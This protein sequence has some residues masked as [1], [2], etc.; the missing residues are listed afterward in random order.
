MIKVSLIKV[1]VEREEFFAEAGR[2][3]VLRRLGKNRPVAD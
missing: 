2:K 1:A 3:A